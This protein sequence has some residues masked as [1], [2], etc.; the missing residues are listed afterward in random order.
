M[1]SV[2]RSL[3]DVFARAPQAPDSATNMNA[4]A[5]RIEAKTRLVRARY[6][7][8]QTSAANRKHWGAADGL[9]AVGANSPSVRKLLRDR[10]RYEVANNGYFDG[11]GSTLANDAIGTDV[12][13]QV[14]CDD[15]V[16]ERFIEEA[17]AEWADLI[18]LPQILWTMRLAKFQDGEAFALL[19]T[20]PLLD[21]PVKLSLRLVEADQVASPLLMLEQPQHVDGIVF[22]AYDNPI[23]YHVLKAHPGDPYATFGMDDF[24]VVAAANVLHY[25]RVRRAGQRRG[26]P[27]IVSTLGLGADG[28]R[29][30][31]A[32]VAAAETAANQSMVLQSDAPPPSEDDDEEDVIEPMDTITL[33]K[34]TA[35]VLP[36][37]YKLGQMD[38]VQPTTT[39]GGFKREIVAEMG[40]PVCMPFNIAAADSSGYNYASGRLDDQVYRRS[41]RIERG[42]CVK[43]VLDPLFLAWFREAKLIDKFLP[44]SL[45]ATLRRMKRTWL[46][47]GHEHVDP[48]KEASAQE[49]RLRNRTT[50]LARIFGEQGLDW[51]EEVEQ[52]AR[53]VKKLAELGLTEQE[54]LPSQ[55]KSGTANDQVDD[56][57]DGDGEAETK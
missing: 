17:W 52:R 1:A 21:F 5:A 16:A 22:D 27:E 48:V 54:A 28:R 47:D 3:R 33:E 13:L 8:A 30:R 38:A 57:E 14:R 46:F 43:Q 36:R 9:S 51:Q 53:E 11:I 39:F 10:T 49:T 44:N 37:G 31:G 23:A 25:F 18:G 24:D 19:L 34:N 15:P 29:Y 32:V 45:R 35:T 55:Q 40:R 4:D 7:A 50:T 6:D 56:K 42:L 12:S 20:N 26:V 41:T 2:W